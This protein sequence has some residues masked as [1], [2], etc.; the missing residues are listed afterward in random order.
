MVDVFSEIVIDRS[1]AE[2]ASYATDPGNAPEW[3]DNIHSADWKTEPVVKLGAQI[4]FVAKFMGKE[5][6]YVYEIVEFVPDEKMVMRTADGPFPME[7][8]YTWEATVNGQTKMTLRNRG[9]PKGFSKFFSF[10]MV[11][12]MRKANRK[13]LKKIKEILESQD[14]SRSS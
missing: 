14:N 11:P 6:A 8:I 9:Q 4:A 2:V 10:M 5:L 1:Q 7:T 12:M 13:D 3:Y